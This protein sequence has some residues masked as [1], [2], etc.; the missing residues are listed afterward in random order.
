MSP[1]PRAPQP[2]NPPA[3]DPRTP[4]LV[5]LPLPQSLLRKTSSLGR[6]GPDGG[7]DGEGGEGGEEDEEQQLLLASSSRRPGGLQ[8]GEQT[9]DPSAVIEGA[10]ARLKSLIDG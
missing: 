5:F 9:F 3:P 10:D 4:T 7:P 6:G 2:P 8:G 1:R